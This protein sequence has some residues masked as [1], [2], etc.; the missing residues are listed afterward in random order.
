MMFYSLKDEFF[1][2][3][4][5]RSRVHFGPSN[6][7]LIQGNNAEGIWHKFIRQPERNEQIL[8]TSLGCV[9]SKLHRRQIPVS[10]Q[11]IQL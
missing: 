3:D 11:N 8:S 9:Y 7:H 2:P 10:I 4:G 5:I 1:V 6:F